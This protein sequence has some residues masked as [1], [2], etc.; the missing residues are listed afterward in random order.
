MITLLAGLPSNVVAA[1]ATGH[2]TAE[3]YETILMPAVGEAAA[4]KDKI[5]LLYVLGDGFEGYDIGAAVDDARMG[6]HHWASF[7]R[8][9]LVTDHAAYG[10]LAKAFGFMMP[11]EVRV[12]PAS[13]LEDAKAW[14][15]E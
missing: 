14:V 9:G 11:G 7:D 5:R 6:M 8:I 2:V 10:S 13:A 15:S 3:D 12:F 4:S 1:Q